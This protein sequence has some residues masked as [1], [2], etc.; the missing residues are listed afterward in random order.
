MC[1]TDMNLLLWCLLPQVQVSPPFPLAF[2]SILLCS[3][4]PRLYCRGLYMAQR[5]TISRLGL[6]ALAMALAGCGQVTRQMTLRSEPSGA[7]VYLNGQ[8]VGRTPCTVDF[9]WYGRYDV[10]L[11]REG[12]QTVKTTQDV[13]APWWQ[14]I[15]LDLLSDILPG[16][17][18]DHHEYAFVLKPQSE[19]GVAGPVLI[20]RATSLRPMLESG[21]Y[22][23]KPTSKPATEP[24]DDATTPPATP[25]DDSAPGASHQ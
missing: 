21:E 13:P 25:P 4:S 23:R 8:E 11:R 24:T 5:S 20:D 17:K 16:R 2:P 19:T 7:L 6:A 22:T 18:V 14:W 1:Y 10:V 12:S 15:P 3:H 9:T